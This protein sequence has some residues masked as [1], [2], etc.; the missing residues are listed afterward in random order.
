[1]P[2][3]EVE[4]TP[5]G[6]SRPHRPSIGGPRPPCPSIGSTLAG[7]ICR[8][9]SAPA[10]TILDPI[11]FGLSRS[12]ARYVELRDRYPRIEIMMG[13]GNVSELTVPVSFLL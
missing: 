1:M 8:P 6:T 3:H 7:S 10:T 12:L 9:K 4:D 2:G 13:T 11:H 5:L